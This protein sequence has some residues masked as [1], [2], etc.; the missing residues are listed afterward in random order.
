M[1][2]SLEQ[3]GPNTWRIV[4]SAGFDAH[5]KRVK[6]T[7]TVHGTKR[8][9]EREKA[10]LD[11]DVKAHRIGASAGMTLE[12]WAKQWLGLMQK[13]LAP[14][15][16]A[17]YEAHLRQRILPAL[18][19]LPLDRIEPRHIITWLDQ[20]HA[21]SNMRQVRAASAARAAGQVA[22]DPEPISGATQLRHFR[23]LTAMLQDAVYR[24]I[25][26]ANPA[27]AVEPP[28]ADRREA[29]HYGRQQIT[30]LLTAL[31]DEPLPFRVLVLLA[32]T[33]GARRGEL[34][35]LTW[36]D[37]NWDEKRLRI[38]QAAYYVPGQGQSVKAPKTAYSVR[39]VPLVE[40]AAGSRAAARLGGCPSPEPCQRGR[41]LGGRQLHLYRTIRQVD[42]YR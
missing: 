12:E 15:T 1:A 38:R 19:S 13:K 8:E 41:S 31:E 35:A 18:G 21:T 28:R 5:G 16:L 14:R 29:Q 36:Q 2:G 22:E 27:R 3:R 26:P 23:T 40:K 20:L 42:V 34:I 24:G 39:Y 25:I 4:V 7:R 32:L 30:A 6:I 11:A 9:A 17:S 10:R 33:T 37:V